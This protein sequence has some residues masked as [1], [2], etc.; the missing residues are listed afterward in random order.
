MENKD[1]EVQYAVRDALEEERKKVEEKAQEISGGDVVAA[2][3]LGLFP[4]VGF[5][6][7]IVHLAKGRTNKGLLYMGAAVAL[8]ILALMFLYS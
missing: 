3:C 7:G 1:K 8:F 6:F 2:G 4:I 5:I